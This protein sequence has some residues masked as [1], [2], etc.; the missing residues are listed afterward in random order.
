[1]I[2]MT[3]PDLQFP[4]NPSILTLELFCFIV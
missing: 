2:G 4:T 3:L 1:M